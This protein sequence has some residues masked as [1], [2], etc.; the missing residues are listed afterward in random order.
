MYIRARR[1][2]ADVKKRV[3]T[4]ETSA[5]E[6][7]SLLEGAVGGESHTDD[8]SFSKKNK[9]AS[10]FENSLLDLGEKKPE[11]QAKDEEDYSSAITHY[12]FPKEWGKISH[13]ILPNCIW[14]FTAFLVVSTIILT[15]IHEVSESGK[16]SSSSPA[17]N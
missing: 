14:I 10:I 11:E 17:F 3:L 9:L 5:N 2:H 13:Q 7:T 1:W 15:I 8:D 6:R 4:E 12:A 16:S